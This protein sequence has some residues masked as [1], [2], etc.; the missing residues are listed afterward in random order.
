M[1]KKLSGGANG[2][3]AFNCGFQGPF[4]NPHEVHAQRKKP[5]QPT[6]R[7]ETDFTSLEEAQ[8]QLQL[9]EWRA[10]VVDDT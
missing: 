7:V 9:E 3:K 4:R 10:R 8:K 1:K 5:L 2:K 6:L